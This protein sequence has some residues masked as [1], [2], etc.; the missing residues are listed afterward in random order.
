MD[1]S[2]NI[3]ILDSLVADVRAIIEEGR[4]QAFAVAGKVVIMTYW[5]VGRRIVEEEQRGKARAD[6]GKKIIPALADKLTVEYG[7]GYSRRNLAYFRKFYLLFTDLGILHTRVQNLNWSHIRR[8]LS[9]SNP[10][11][12]EWYL[13]MAAEDMWSVK[14]LDRNIATQ[15]YERRLA[16]QLENIAD[17]TLKRESDPMEYIKNPMV[18]EF[19]GFRRDDNY[20][21]SQLEQAL[22]NNLEK[23]ILELGRGFA[24]VER[25]QHIVTDTADFYIDLVFYNFKMKRFVIFELKTHKLTHQDIGQLDMY[26]RMYDDLVKGADDAPT[27]GV[28]LCTDTDNTIARYSVLHDSDQL[29]ATKYMTYMPT[30]EEL[31]NEIEQQKRF[32]LEQHG[33]EDII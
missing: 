7:S 8:I 5:H 12:R 22:V 21:E 23:F 27:I 4:R 24:F 18:A 31:R 25:Q 1:K 13:K 19:M 10:E 30:E 15:Y 32:F 17:Q 2:D 3:V 20:S 9:V 26:V 6:Y 28:L 16:N 11:A 14:T 33:N 29:Y